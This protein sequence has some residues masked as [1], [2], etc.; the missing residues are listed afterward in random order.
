MRI[1][2]LINGMTGYLDAQFRALHAL[3][4]ELFVVMPGSPDVAVGAM[5]DTAFSGFAMESYARV[6]EWPAQPDPD[7]LVATMREWDP[8]AVLMWSW[9]FSPAYRAVMKDVPPRVSRGLVMDTLW[10]ATP[11]QWLGRMTHRWYIDPIADFA[12]VASDRTEWFARRLGFSAADIVRAWVSAD[13]DLFTSEPRSGEELIGR[14]SFL[15]VGRL[16]DHKGADVLADAYVRYREISADPWDLHIVGIGPMQPL[17]E[18]IDG[19]KLHGFTPPA[20]VAALMREVSCFVLP[21]RIEPYGAVLHEAAASALPILSSDFAGAMPWFM[22][23]GQN[24]WI[25]PAGDAESLAQ[26]M[27]RM[28][29]ASASRLTGMSRVSRAL[30]ERLSPHGFAQY[31]TEELERRIGAG[32]SRLG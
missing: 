32:G 2:F 28:S 24:G 19:V 4:N 20:D 5:R 13:T 12:F 15:H 23:D 9:N 10:R 8:D 1:A 14:R 3:G 30:S 17:V 7:E 18:H 25:V 26:A 29:T 22:Q 31:L 16:V 21:S 27:V 6:L 11:R